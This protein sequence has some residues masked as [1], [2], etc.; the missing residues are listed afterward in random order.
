MANTKLTCKL[1]RDSLENDIILSF[2]IYI[3]C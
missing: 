3:L 2:Y 1:L